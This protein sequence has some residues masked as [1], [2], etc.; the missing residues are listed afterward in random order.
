MTWVSFDSVC[1]LNGTDIRFDEEEFI[2]RYLMR[3]SRLPDAATFQA[4]VAG[5]HAAINDDPRYYIDGHH[6]YALARWYFRHFAKTANVLKDAR[7][8]ERSLSSCIELSFLDHY[9]LFQQLRNRVVVSS[10]IS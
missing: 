10:L 1:Q 5:I 8:F 4:R 3:N 9:P 7:G 2:K 6:F